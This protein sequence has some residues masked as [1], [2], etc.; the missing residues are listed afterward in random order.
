MIL[1]LVLAYFGRG[2]LE[3]R[4]ESIHRKVDRVSASSLKVKTDLRHHEREALVALH[5]ALTEWEHYLLGAPTLI[6]TASFDE[7]FSNDFYNKE[8]DFLLK[9][10]LASAKLSVLVSNRDIDLKLYELIQQVQV[11]YQPVVNGI[12]NQVID[13]RSEAALLEQ[14]VAASVELEKR[15]EVT[16]ILV[17]KARKNL[18]RVKEI[19]QMLTNL[20]KNA[21]EKQI[22]IQRPLREKFENF[23]ILSQAL[24]YRT[25]ENDQI[26]K[27]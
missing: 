12:I 7:N 23:K 5:L 24:I 25:L 21:S 26:G 18:N 9:V 17:E 10:K 15:G 3:E 14:E 8:D 2:Y 11:S 6:T 13:L 16:P 22:E 20:A 1:I 27:D 19:N 4:I